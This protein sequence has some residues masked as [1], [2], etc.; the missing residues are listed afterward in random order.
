MLLL[1]VSGILLVVSWHMY[2]YTSCRFVRVRRRS[3][4]GGG[5]VSL[6]V[7]RCL[8]NCQPP[9]GLREHLAK[10][11]VEVPQDQGP[12][13]ASPTVGQRTVLDADVW[14]SRVRRGRKAAPA[15]NSRSTH[16]QTSV[17]GGVPD[18]DISRMRHIC[19]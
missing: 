4:L 10:M 6:S 11:D 19:I 9:P 7:L 12:T 15:G 14:L 8:C 17:A 16:G 1:R 5:P 18:A 13:D 2:Q 3:T